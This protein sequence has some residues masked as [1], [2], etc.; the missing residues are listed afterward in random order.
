MGS[1]AEALG[2]EQALRGEQALPRPL[3]LAQILLA[4]LSPPVASIIILT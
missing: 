3:P 1:R 4:Q 2:A